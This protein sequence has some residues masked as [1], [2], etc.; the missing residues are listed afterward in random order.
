MQ[1]YVPPSQRLFHARHRI[2]RDDLKDEPLHMGSTDWTTILDTAVDKD[3]SLIS[4]TV[5]IIDNFAIPRA[6]SLESPAASTRNNKS[7][8]YS[9]SSSSVSS[10]FSDGLFT[11]NTNKNSSGSSSL[12]IRPQ[13]NLSVDSLIQENKRRIND[14]KASLSLIANNNNESLSTHSD[15]S[16]Q[17]QIRSQTKRNILNLKFQNRNLFRRELKLEKFWDN[18][19]NYHTSDV[20]GD[21]L[22]VIRKHNLYWFGIPNDFRLPIYKRCLYHH[23]EQDDPTSFSQHDKNPLYS[24]IRN[25]CNNEEQETLSRAI[26]INLI[27]NVTWLNSRFSDD[28]DRRDVYAI[29]EG[30]FYQNFPNLYYHLKDK[31]RLNVITDFIKP[32]IRNFII[33]ALNK[34]KLDGIGLELLDILI[35]TTYYG[36]DEINVF[37]MDTFIL[38]L[39]KQCHFK[40][41]VNNISEVIM[42]ISKIDCDLVILL[43]DLRSQIDLD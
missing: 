6:N 16:I 39:L 7:T 23:I 12:V 26:F 9:S 3:S 20:D 32:V 30:K 5:P 24:A 18:L 1:G 43:E 28:K 37:L 33:N 22:L 36:R 40:F 35:V 11:P 29:I 34:H 2:T 19:R 41:F 21:L 31:L 42:Q 17:N 10:V 38:H 13:K 4:Y 27:K 8:V 14:E 25:C 15:L